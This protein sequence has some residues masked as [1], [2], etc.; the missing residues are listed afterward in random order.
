M[1]RFL[2]ISQ[3]S[4]FLCISHGKGSF[5]ASFFISIYYFYSKCVIK[6]IFLLIQ[7]LN[8]FPFVFFCAVHII[9]MQL[10]N[11]I[12]LDVIKYSFCEY[13]FCCNSHRKTKTGES[14]FFCSWQFC[15]YCKR[16]SN[17][18]KYIVALYKSSCYFELIYA[19]FTISLF[20]EM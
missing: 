10:L 2:I 1:F 16:I 15:R 3:S 7:L 14:L 11:N 5:A 18:E 13:V 12:L 9:K 6:F 8:R 19:N 20:L 17:Y 4:T